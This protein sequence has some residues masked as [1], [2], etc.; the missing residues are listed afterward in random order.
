MNQATDEPL[1]K[2]DND[3]LVP[4]GIA[5]LFSDDSLSKKSLSSYKEDLPYDMDGPTL[6]TAPQPM[7]KALSSRGLAHQRVYEYG[8]DLNFDQVKI[9]DSNGFKTKN[10]QIP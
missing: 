6:N 1:F 4:K 8:L 10:K 5:N 2:P 3:G 9:S 7:D